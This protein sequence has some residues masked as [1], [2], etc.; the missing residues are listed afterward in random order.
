MP[1]DPHERQL[2]AQ[3]G[4]LLDRTQQL[5]SARYGRELSREDAREILTN[6]TGFFRVLRHME[7]VATGEAL[8]QLPENEET[9]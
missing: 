2:P 4:V 3:D 6:L 8:P 7:R 5:Y 1:R 9:P